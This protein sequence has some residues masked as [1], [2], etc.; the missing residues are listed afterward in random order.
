MRNKNG[1]LN[2]IAHRSPDKA[3]ALISEAGYKKAKTVEQL[4]SQLEDFV[5]KN[6]VKAIQAL[7]K[8]HPDAKIIVAQYQNY[9]EEKKNAEVKPYD[10]ADFANC[11][12]CAVGVA[13]MAANGKNCNK[14]EESKSAEGD[15]KMK[16]SN[17][18]IISGAAVL[19]IALIAIIIATNRKA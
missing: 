3:I 11:G 8:I 19:S 17:T 12:G 1:F 2:C 10:P 9:L 18:L 13:A 5:A 4:Y 7:A 16:L 14:V 6:N 15:D